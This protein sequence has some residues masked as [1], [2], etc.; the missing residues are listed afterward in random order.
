M[1]K[2]ESRVQRVQSISVVGRN[3]RKIQMRHDRREQRNSDD[4]ER[5]RQ[6]LRQKSSV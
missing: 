3:N 5:F 1:G 2:C 4:T 6:T